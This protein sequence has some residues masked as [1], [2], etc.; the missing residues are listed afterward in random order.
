MSLTMLPI[1]ALKLIKSSAKHTQNV[2]SGLQR[3][4]NG[5]N[6]TMGSM[7]R[8]LVSP[9]RAAA[10]HNPFLKVCMLLGNALLTCLPC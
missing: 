1:V 10:T 4:R 8:E 2:E 3:C 5:L 7:V 9:T 6:T